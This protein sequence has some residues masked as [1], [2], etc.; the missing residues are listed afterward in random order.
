[1]S[2]GDNGYSAPTFVSFSCS[3]KSAIKTIKKPPQKNVRVKQCN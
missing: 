1:M 2:G 3:N